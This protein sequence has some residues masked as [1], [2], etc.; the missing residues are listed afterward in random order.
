MLYE[1]MSR[2]NPEYRQAL[3]LTYFEEMSADEVANV[4]KKNRKQ[5]YNLIARGKEALK[6]RLMEMGYEG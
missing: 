4:L 3:Y 5:V 2:I 6:N 1:A